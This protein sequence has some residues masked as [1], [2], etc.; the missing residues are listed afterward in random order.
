ML[1]VRGTEPAADWGGGGFYLK[2]FGEECEILPAFRDEPGAENIFS[3]IGDAIGI[4]GIDNFDSE[5]FEGIEQH[6]PDV[7]EGDG[8][9]VV[10]VPQQDVAIEAVEAG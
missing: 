8:G 1:N 4:R 9:V 3:G 2:G 7:G 6:S 5:E 10:V